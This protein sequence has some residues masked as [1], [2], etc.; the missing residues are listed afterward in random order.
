MFKEGLIQ[1]H[2]FG[3]QNIDHQKALFDCGASYK[4]NRMNL[5]KLPWENG[6]YLEILS[7]DGHRN[8]NLTFL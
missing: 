7:E 3:M 4:P 5:A 8:L 2:N 6:V 1:N